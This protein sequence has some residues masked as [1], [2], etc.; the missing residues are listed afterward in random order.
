[1]EKEIVEN[2]IKMIYILAQDKY[3]T[4]KDLIEILEKDQV[5]GEV[6]DMLD[7]LTNK[8]LI[9]ID[10]LGIIL[11]GKGLELAKKT[12][13]KHEL[14]ESFLRR[15]LELDEDQ[16]HEESERLE[17][18]ISD[19]LVNK[20]QAYLEKS[21]DF[22]EKNT[23]VPLTW[24]KEGQQGK[25]HSINGGWRVVQRLSHLG[26]TKGTPVHIIRTS[27]FGGPLEIGVRGSY[28][29]LGYGVAGKVMIEVDLNGT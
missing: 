6:K 1:M 28:Y 17:H 27:P 15:T 2:Y 20:L 4:I 24:L 11:T 22:S 10:D 18:Y 19:E 23:L 14:F 16:A 5:N 29:V 7:S 8:N 21:G 12:Y 25:V 26:L 13:Q 9:S 3:I